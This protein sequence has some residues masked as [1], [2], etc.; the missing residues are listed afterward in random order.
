MSGNYVVKDGQIIGKRDAAGNFR[1]AAEVL[2][3]SA[4]YR[5]LF[6]QRV[7]VGRYTWNISPT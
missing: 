4:A 5:G 6:I 2:K 3:A 7:M 1:P